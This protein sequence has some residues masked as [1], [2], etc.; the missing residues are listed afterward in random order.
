MSYVFC[1]L[2]FFICH[3]SFVFLLLSYLFR[4]ISYFF[5]LLSSFL[6]FPIFVILKIYV[7]SQLYIP[8]DRLMQLGILLF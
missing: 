6:S 3:L 2:S 7:K 8:A 1:L 4:L 5:C